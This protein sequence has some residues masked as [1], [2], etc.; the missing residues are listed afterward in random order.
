MILYIDRDTYE[1]AYPAFLRTS[2]PLADRYQRADRVFMARLS[3]P[4]EGRRLLLLSDE[5]AV[6]ARDALT[7]VGLY[8]RTL[9]WNDRIRAFEARLELR[10]EVEIPHPCPAEVTMQHPKTKTYYCATH[11][12][13]HGAKP[14]W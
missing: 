9:R 11:G 6:E 13:Q 7:H 4:F 10:C 1:E 5:E 3:P 12:A 14:W 8:E 2:P